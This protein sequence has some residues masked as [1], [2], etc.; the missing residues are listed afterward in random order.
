MYKDSNRIGLNVDD[1]ELEAMIKAAAE[2]AESAV[3]TKGATRQQLDG[4]EDMALKMLRSNLSLR[5]QQKI[6]EAT[7]IQTTAPSLRA[8][9]KRYFPEEWAAYLARTARGQLKN[10]LLAEPVGAE[11]AEIEAFLAGKPAQPQVEANKEQVATPG[12]AATAIAAKSEKSGGMK[13]V[14]DLRK[15]ADSH[16]WDQY[17][18]N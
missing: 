8:Y 6:W 5:E 17:G 2:K 13:T 16:D 15:N 14:A 9:F 18:D 12:E 11:K 10:R 4:R 3:R 7:G 1:D